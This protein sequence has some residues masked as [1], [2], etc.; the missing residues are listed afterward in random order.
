MVDSTLNTAEQR[1]LEH[2]VATF[3]DGQFHYPMTPTIQVHVPE[4]SNVW[5]KDES[6]G[7]T[8]THKDRMAMEIVA[9]YQHMLEA[10]QQQGFDDPL[11]HFSLISSG[12]AALAIQTQLRRFGLPALKVLMEQ[13]SPKLMQ[14][15]LADLGCQVYV[16]DLSKRSLMPP[17]ILRLTDNP[18]GFDFTS[19]SGYCE[20][21]RNYNE[22]SSQVLDQDPAFVFVPFGT[23][24]LYLNLLHV[25]GESV[26]ARSKSA[27]RCTLL[28]A[29]TDSP[30]SK[31]VKLYAPFLPFAEAPKTLRYAR[32]SGWCDPKSGLWVVEEP[33]IERGHA[34]MAANGIS[35]EYSGAAGLGLLYQIADQVPLDAKILVVNTGKAKFPLGL[36]AA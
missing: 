9:H 18:R 11:P 25:A 15:Y 5:V 29:T 10:K 12:S 20:T 17:D 24:Q 22:L 28:G 35:A 27:Q 6:V 3:R 2:L 7:P 36:L 14:E 13:T 33:F 16:A 32:A 26:F 1:T 8:G 23:G 30:T 19:N 34:L 4:F 21:H 31:A